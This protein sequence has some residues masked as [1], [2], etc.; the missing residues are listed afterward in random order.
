M[1]SSH[2][3][4]LRL[5]PVVALGLLLSHPLRAAEPIE[6]LRDGIV[7]KLAV[8]KGRAVLNWRFEK[9]IPAPVTSVK[10]TFNGRSV[11]EM[12]VNFYP[13]PSDRTAILAL[14]DV[15][16]GPARSQAIALE[17]VRILALYDFA[18]PNQGFAMGQFADKVSIA[19]PVDGQPLD[20]LEATLRFTDPE[21]APQLGGAIT[22]ATELI[23][24][25]KVARRAVF[26]FTDG[27][28]EMPLDTAKLIAA[29][30]AA[31]VAFYFV[32]ER[33][34]RPS[35]TDAL[36]QIAAET[37][38]GYF[39]GADAKAFVRGDPV[40]FIESG[41]SATPDL[42][43]ARL[44][45]WE[46]ESRLEV[47]ISYG[48]AD[49]VVASPIT[50]RAADW[51]EVTDYLWANHGREIAIG[52]AAIGWAMA[53]AG[54]SSAVACRQRVR[55]RNTHGQGA[56]EANYVNRAVLDNA[57]DPNTD[58]G[59][60]GLPDLEAVQPQPALADEPPAN[61]AT[62]HKATFPEITAGP[63]VALRLYK[64]DGVSF[65]D[66]PLEGDAISIGRAA[67]N[68]IELKE[69]TVSS[70]HARL[71]LNAHGGYALENLSR[72]NPTR[73][74]DERVLHR[75]LQDGDRI[76]IGG[77]KAMFV[78]YDTGL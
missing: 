76:D 68:D 24:T 10:A 23:A 26:I 20:P 65:V 12:V 59:E 3:Q 56:T 19:V 8:E 5:V 7:A 33:S 18:R 4:L 21:E 71:V 27:H 57:S 54:F 66:L 28:S 15:S 43:N 44:Y 48:N 63:T 42:S 46:K 11:P 9:D 14:A 38:G 39:E 70:R 40:R 1:R 64:S 50:V 62:E 52:G 75:N 31:D 25:E 16:G 45:P 67:G 74:N 34:D 73:V 13:Q 36:K 78:K 60:P 53:I 32:V 49:L 22:F 77:V 41:A 51:K 6:A 61:D 58:D 72:T 55:Q 69:A 35:S 29:A 17:K 37:H 30:R 2:W 47:S